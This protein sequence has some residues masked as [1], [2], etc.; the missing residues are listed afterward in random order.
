MAGGL[1]G[2]LT[3]LFCF[4]LASA[5]LWGATLSPWGVVVASGRARISDSNAEVGANVYDTDQLST[6]GS[7][8]LQVRSNEAQLYLA[9]ST[10][11]TLMAAG[12]TPCASL[13]FGTAMFSTRRGSSF[14]LCVGYARIYPQSVAPVTGQVTVVSPKELLVSSRRGSLAVTVG[15]QTQIVPEGTSYR[16]FLDLPAGPEDAQSPG[17][18]GFQRPAPAG[19]ARFAIVASAATAI[20]TAFAIDEVLESPDKP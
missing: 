11:A 20:V 19:R 6:E 4:A 2:A 9:G 3:L 17:P 18:G 5:P 12:P 1:R 8:L 14:G 7:G 16:V 13:L 10:D 15:H